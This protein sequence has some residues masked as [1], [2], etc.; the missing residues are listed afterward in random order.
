MPVGIPGG[1]SELLVSEQL[2]DR[3]EVGAVHS[4]LTGRG[5]SQVIDG[6]VRDL[7]LFAGAD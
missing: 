5:V 2:P 3:M 7:S 1:H 4:E 6:E